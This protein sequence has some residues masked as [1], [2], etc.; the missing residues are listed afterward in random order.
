ME[1]SIRN[2]ENICIGAN[3]REERL[4][5]NLGQTQLVRLLQLQGVSITRETPVKIE[6]GTQHIKVSQLKAIK[7]C[8][9]VSYED[10]IR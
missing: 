1:D 10:L 8:L 4:R 9:D 7:E 5:R 2:D 3:I 6:R